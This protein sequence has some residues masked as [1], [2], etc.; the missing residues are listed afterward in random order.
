MN[1]PV[2]IRTLSALLLAPPLLYL[3]LVGPAY[4]LFLLFIP[5]AMLLISEWHGLREP[6]S[7]PRLLPLLIGVLLI[8]LSGPTGI[9][10]E[11][12]TG[13]GGWVTVARLPVS[14]SCNV[15]LVLL[16]AEG[17]W[18]HRPGVPVLEDVGRRFFGVLYCAL[19]LLLLLE[20]RAAEQGGLLICFLLLT[21]WATDV[22]AFFA[23]RRWG[24][25]KLAPHISPGKTYA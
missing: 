24:R 6:L 23:G 12:A 19:P 8:L 21:I 9:G 11:T 4:L 15:L 5:V 25:S 16:F 3:L 10:T 7:L 1:S 13:W 18:H 22:G 17:L 2:I 20:V 14:L